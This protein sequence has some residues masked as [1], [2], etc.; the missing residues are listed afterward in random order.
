[1]EKRRIVRLLEEVSSSVASYISE[2]WILIHYESSDKQKR[3]PLQYAELLEK[4]YLADN[5]ELIT[6]YC[7]LMASAEA[8]YNE[9]D[10]T[11][12]G[13]NDAND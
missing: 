10:T 1:M 6:K 7:H 8:F 3:L 2:L 11:I 5:A 13:I 12:K 4:L 9:L